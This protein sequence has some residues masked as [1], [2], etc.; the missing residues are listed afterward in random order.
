[1]EEEEFLNNVNRFVSTG[2]L[3][4]VSDIFNVQQGVRQGKKNVFKITK[5]EYKLFSK[6]EKA[7]FR[8]VIDNDAIKDG[9][10]F[11]KK[12][13]WYPYNQS[14]LIFR[15]EKEMKDNTFFN[16]K[17]KPY[18]SD[19]KKRAGNQEWWEHTRPRNWQFEKQMKLVSTEFGKSDSF[20]IDKTGKFVVE[21]GY[22]WMPRKPFVIDDYY[23]YLS[24][25]SSDTFD[26]L[27]SIYS[28][29][30]AGGNWY[31]LGKKYTKNIPIPNVS[32]Q[33]VR[34]SGHYFRL[35]ELG[36]ELEDGKP[37]AKYAIRDVVKIYYPNI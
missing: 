20:A 35:A 16:D 10:L 2:Q 25:F 3:A 34:E 9:Q 22:A 7:L 8:P 12:Y 17:I 29:Q 37:Y 31:D 11:E 13:I 18:K 27:L 14:G 24:I 15:S 26:F 1:M 36:K 33:G 32:L 23:F 30:L 28:K 5:E 21:R 4:F 6:N 19:L